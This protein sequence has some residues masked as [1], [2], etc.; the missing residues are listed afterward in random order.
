MRSNHRSTD[1]AT[2]S[3]PRIDPE[4]SSVT[5]T[6]GSSASSFSAC[7]QGSVEVS[8][9]TIPDVS[10]ICSVATSLLLTVPLFTWNVSWKIPWKSFGEQGQRTK[11]NIAIPMGESCLSPVSRCTVKRSAF[12]SY[13]NLCSQEWNTSRISFP[14]FPTNKESC[15]FSIGMT[16]MKVRR[17]GIEQ[18]EW[19]TTWFPLWPHKTSQQSQTRRKNVR[20]KIRTCHR[21][22]GIPE[23]IFV[24]C[25]ICGY[26][27]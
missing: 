19:I 15:L 21:S 5:L 13:V 6:N 26:T 25:F 10:D 27:D 8:R 18:H 2:L 16:N 7:V 1:C 20:W 9:E 11:S 14:V 24:R 22:S 3:T 23:N 4:V 12:H 17:V